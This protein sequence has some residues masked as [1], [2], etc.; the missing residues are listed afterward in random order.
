MYQYTGSKI[1]ILCKPEYC[2]QASFKKKK[3]LLKTAMILFFMIQAEEI[4]LNYMQNAIFLLM[5]YILHIVMN[6]RIINFVNGVF[7]WS[8]FWIF[9]CKY[10]TSVVVT[11]KWKETGMW[12]STWLAVPILSGQS[13]GKSTCT[14]FSFT[15]QGGSSRGTGRG[16]GRGQGRVL[17]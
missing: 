12:G 5:P 8:S 1:W 4:E 14:L 9:D 13:F 17:G 7:P 10:F 3:K 6:W 2:F 15:F 11:R 16:R